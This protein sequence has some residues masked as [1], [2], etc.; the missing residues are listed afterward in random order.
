MR[1]YRDVLRTPGVLNVT[2]S[3]LFARLPLGMLNLAILMHVQ[4]KTGSY[5]LAG[6]AV[7]CVSIG[8]ALA[9]PVTARIAGR[10]M[11]ITLIVAALTNGVAMLALAFA[12]ASG[13]LLLMLGVLI[14]ASVP[15]LMPVVRALYPQLVP[16]D[17]VRALFA[18]DTT[19][20]EL[21]WV[22]G[23]VATTF[24]ASALSTAIPLVVSAGVTV[25]GTGWF[26]LGA[27]HLRPHTG[28][29]ASAF[30]RVIANRAV[31]LAMVASLALVAS[32]MALEVGIVAALGRTGV[33]AGLAIA[34]AS[35]GS[36]VGGLAFGHRR[37]GLAGLVAALGIVAVGTTVFSLVDNLALQFCALFVSGLGFAPAMS[38]LYLMVSREIEEHSAAEAFGWLNSAALVGG[39]TGTALAGVAADGHGASGAVVVAAV[40][41][42]LAACSPIVARM[43]GPLRGLSDQPEATDVHAVHGPDPTC[44]GGADLECARPDQVTRCR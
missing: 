6:A 4:S 9:M 10:A 39:A 25:V 35:V 7:A 43:A 34:V 1:V 40:L 38:A 29:A 42:T 21:I 41:A 28:K 31:I 11:V 5:A 27:R 17:G 36:L 20:Q 2:A 16:S 37:F 12:G 14:G 23:P 32:F 18:F 24:L 3:Q 15:P 30:G 44:G 13:P 19:A 33:T 8:E 26:L 22:V